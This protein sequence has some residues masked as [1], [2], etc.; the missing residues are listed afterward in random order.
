MIYVL[1]YSQNKKQ[2]YEIIEPDK[3]RSLSMVIPCF[4]EEKSIGKNIE[5]FLAS[6]YKGLK[7]LIIV[8]DCSTDNSYKIIKEYARKYSRVI[9]LQT[10][11]NTRRAAGAK[12]FGI[13]YVNIYLNIL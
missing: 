2:I 1:T 11:K 4:N 8:D 6:D 3:T 5:T 7:K 10:P 9:A 13:K 12:N